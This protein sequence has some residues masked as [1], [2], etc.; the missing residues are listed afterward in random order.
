VGDLVSVTRRAEPVKRNHVQLCTLRPLWGGQVTFFLRKELGCDPGL[1][2]CAL[3]W[4]FRRA[5]S[6]PRGWI[7]L[8]A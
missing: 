2:F 1:T 3:P 8:F 6:A 5:Q 4:D 7:M